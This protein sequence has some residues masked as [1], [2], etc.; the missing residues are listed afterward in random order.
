MSDP[1]PS[2]ELGKVYDSTGPSNEQIVI[3]LKET[4]V[5]LGTFIESQKRQL[6]NLADLLKEGG[7]LNE[8]LSTRLENLRAVRRAEK[9]PEIEA[10]FTN[11]QG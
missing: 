9:R 11:P 2:L 6:K 5:N 8:Q 3:M 7:Q 10:L 1:T 4:W